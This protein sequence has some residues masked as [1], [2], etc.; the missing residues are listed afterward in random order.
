M[1]FS[2]WRPVGSDRI[3]KSRLTAAHIRVTPGM[4]RSG[5]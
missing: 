1:G 3:L 4:G 5:D 2:Q